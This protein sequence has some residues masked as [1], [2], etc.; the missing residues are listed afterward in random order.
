ML[1]SCP[2]ITVNYC[3]LVSIKRSSMSSLL[4]IH[5]CHPSFPS[6][7]LIRPVLDS[8]LILTGFDRMQQ[9]F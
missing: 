5:I 4:V 6:V 7:G 8:V 9:K 3:V 1:I 2:Y